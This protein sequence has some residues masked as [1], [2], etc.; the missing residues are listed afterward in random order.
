MKT[1][2]FVL[3]Y[4][5]LVFGKTKGMRSEKNLLTIARAEIELPSIEVSEAPVVLTYA[6]NG[7]AENPIRAYDGMFLSNSLRFSLGAIEN[8]HLEFIALGAFGNNNHPLYGELGRLIKAA[9]KY[10]DGATKPANLEAA[11]NGRT[12]NG[13]HSAITPWASIEQSKRVESDLLRW[14]EAAFKNPRGYMIGGEYCTKV[15]EPVFRLD[16]ESGE[17]S[18]STRDGWFSPDYLYFPINDLEALND[19]A[20]QQGIKLAPLTTT[21]EIVDPIPFGKNFAGEQL[22]EISRF[23]IDS[24]VKLV[25]RE[26]RDDGVHERFL[27]KVEPDLYLSACRLRDMLMEGHQEYSSILQGLTQFM[28]CLSSSRCLSLTYNYEFDDVMENIEFWSKR[29]KPVDMFPAERVFVC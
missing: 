15:A 25:K 6:I 16:R 9:L 4:P 29:L 22:V 12:Y 21:V 8:E 2:R 10:L 14:S 19:F 11:V 7:F 27:Q 1:E 20:D 18:V 3:P 24:F 23:V 17:I 13:S 26:M 5:A 28:D